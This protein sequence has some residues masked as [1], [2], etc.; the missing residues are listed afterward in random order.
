MKKDEI[1]EPNLV[2]KLLE[3]NCKTINDIRDKEFKG[4]K[5]TDNEII[6]LHNFDKYRIFILN[7]E[8]SEEIFHKKYMQLQALANLSP[9][10]EFLKE[11]YII[12]N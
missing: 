2:K 12:T 11:K 6:A 1:I 7:N 10:E 5:L 8:D 4:D 9:F 3:S